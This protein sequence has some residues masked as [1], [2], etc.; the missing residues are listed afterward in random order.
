[1]QVSRCLW[2]LTFLPRC[3][4]LFQLSYF[5]NHVLKFHDFCNR[6]WEHILK[7]F[8]SAYLNNFIIA[9]FYLSWKHG[10]LTKFVY[11]WYVV[12]KVIE[13]NFI[14]FVVIKFGQIVGHK[15]SF[16]IRLKFIIFWGKSTSYKSS[17]FIYWTNIVYKYGTT[18][19][20]FTWFLPFCCWC[21]AYNY[22]ITKK[23]L[24][25]Y[26]LYHNFKTT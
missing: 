11:G 3:A 2:L 26:V 4:N 22:T 14:S 18:L 6:Y 16:S 7:C 20:P 5:N 24:D 21:Y 9:L 13:N 15:F 25:M 12:T 17:L 23:K 1:L 10:I 8:E 19:W